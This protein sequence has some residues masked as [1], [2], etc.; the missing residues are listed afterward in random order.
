VFFRV[1][2][3]LC[4]VGPPV[5]FPLIFLGWVFAEQSPLLALVGR[6]ALA[7]FVGLGITGAILAVLLLFCGLRL[8]C[9]F[10]GERG[11]FC[12]SKEA[13]VCLLCERCGLVQ[14]SGFLKLHLVRQWE[15]GPPE[16]TD[17]EEESMPSD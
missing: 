7:I 3:Y 15:H 5:L 9:P 8:R 17:D 11:D 6:T 14:G 12:G 16:E 13:G 4:V 2:Y 10:C 1:W